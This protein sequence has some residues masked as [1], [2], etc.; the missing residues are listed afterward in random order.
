MDECRRKFEALFAE[1]ERLDADAHRTRRNGRLRRM[2]RDPEQYENGTTQSAWNYFAD[3]WHL[4]MESETV[5]PLRAELAQAQSDRQREH[6]AR[7]KAVGDYDALRAKVDEHNRACVD[8]CETRSAMDGPMGELCRAMQR[9]SKARCSDCSRLNMI[10][11]SD[12]N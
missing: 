8:Y 9:T 11:V 4:R 6:D 10:E 1:H 2:T 5:A 3:G 7:C 12:D